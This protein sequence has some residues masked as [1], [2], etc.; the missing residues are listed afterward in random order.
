MSK[1]C[2]RIFISFL[3]IIAA[4][5]I[6]ASLRAEDVATSASPAP[7]TVA[8]LPPLKVEGNLLTSGGKAV[9]LRGLDWGWWHLMG[10]IYTEADMQNV[11]RWG[12]N[13][14]RLS[15]SYNDLETDDNPAVWKEQGFEDLDE[16]VRWGRQYGIYV[17]LDMHVVPGGQSD[18]SYCAG[19]HNLIWTD[20][21][22]QERFIALWKE[23]A[24]RYRDQ[25]AV[26]AYELVNEPGS[27]QKTSDLLRG[28]DQRA[29]AAIRAVDPG[30]VIVV[31]GDNG[32]GPGDLIDAMKFSDDNILYTFHWY[33]GAGGNEDW[34]STAR[35]EPGISSTF[36]PY[37]GDSRLRPAPII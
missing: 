16:V 35:L 6:A 3:V 20:A 7:G 30:K 10:T 37:R 1:A 5:R 8:E 9:R 11:A 25:P 29:I 2:A 15:F 19:G 22:A 28:M 34:I 4:L 27:H 18:A 36:N 33:L 23:I 17:I 31:G 13:V 32:S 24:R 26:G 14:I 12:A 21:I